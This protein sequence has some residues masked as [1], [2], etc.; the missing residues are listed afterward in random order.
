MAIRPTHSTVSLISA[1]SSA[2]L[3]MMTEEDSSTNLLRDSGSGIN[4]EANPVR[5]GRA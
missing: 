2:R 5:S 3:A 1:V 4:L